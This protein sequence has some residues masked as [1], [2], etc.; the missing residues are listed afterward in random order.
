[1]DRSTLER[2]HSMGSS[3]RLTLLQVLITSSTKPTQSGNSRC[4]TPNPGGALGECS[5]STRVVV[6]INFKG[7]TTGHM[8]EAN[9]CNNLKK[10]SWNPNIGTF[11][12]R[13]AH[14]IEDSAEPAIR[15]K[16]TATR[17]VFVEMVRG[18]GAQIIGVTT[19]YLEILISSAKINPEVI[20]LVLP[21]SSTFWTD[22]P[23]NP[24][25]TEEVFNSKTFSDD[26][27]T[28]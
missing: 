23:F 4:R 1:M 27:F 3:F 10:G 17:R 12:T 16:R 20:T 6:I 2:S 11:R 14:I 24:A 7:P 9:S 28:L 8:R 22:P 13:Y 25:I 5:K 18:A 15:L 19:S 21:L 26:R